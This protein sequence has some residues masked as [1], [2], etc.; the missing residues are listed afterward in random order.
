[1]CIWI[2]DRCLC[3][4]VLNTVVRG[5]WA[6]VKQESGFVESVIVVLPFPA[7]N[8]C[9]DPAWIWRGKELSSNS[10]SNTVHCSIILGNWLAGW[11]AERL[12]SASREGNIPGAIIPFLF[13]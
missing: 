3:C 4:E 11:L 7:C 5:D 2:I 10:S 9:L 12:C 13:C 8:I 6:R 1:M